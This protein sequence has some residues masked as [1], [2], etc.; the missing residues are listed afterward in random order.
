MF[1]DFYLLYIWFDFMN[2][3]WFNNSVSA[4]CSPESGNTLRPLPP[5]PLPLRIA[6]IFCHIV[7]GVQSSPSLGNVTTV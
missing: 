3:I 6:I 2:L 7:T 4:L 1:S 5:S